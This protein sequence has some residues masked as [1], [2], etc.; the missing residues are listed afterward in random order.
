MGALD[1]TAQRPLALKYLIDLAPSTA[2]TLAASLRTRVLTPAP[3]R[4]FIGFSRDASVIKGSR[5]RK[6]CDPDVGSPAQRASRASSS[7]SAAAATRVL[8]RPTLEVA[9]DLLARCSSIGR[10]QG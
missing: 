2:A 4:R 9:P 6:G 3:Y 7:N 1:N 10:R 8:R 5:P